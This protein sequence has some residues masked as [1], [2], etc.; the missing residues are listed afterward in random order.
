MIDASIAL[1][2][3]KGVAPLDYVGTIQ[4]AQGIKS[5][6]AAEAATRAGIPGIQAESDIKAQ[7]AAAQK[8]L[9]SNKAKYTR[10]DAKTGQRIVDYRAAGTDLADNGFVTAAQGMLGK[11]AQN[12]TADL[13]ASQNQ[14]KTD[15]DA[16]AHREKL[17][18]FAIARA[19]DAA[20]L[21][22]S[23][24][25]AQ[26]QATLDKW[27]QGTVS[28]VGQEVADMVFGERF[29]VGA[30]ITP[31][32]AGA[33]SQATITPTQQEANRLTEQGQVL[34][35]RQVAVSEEQSRQAGASGGVAATDRDPNS[36][37]SV[38]AR[39]QAIA[40]GADPTVVGRL[41]R[42]EMMATPGVKELIVSQVPSEPA[43]AA[44]ATK[45]KEYSADKG[46]LDQAIPIAQSLVKSYGKPGSIARARW[47]DLIAQ[48]P[49]FAA[50]DAAI[51]AYNKRTGSNLRIEDGFEAIMSKLKVES[52]KL[53]ELT[54]GEKELSQTPSF[55]GAST[56]TA[57]PN[58]VTATEQ[59]A[60]DAEGGFQRIM[61]EFGGDVN[62]AKVELAAIRDGI[63]K[64]P[65]GKDNND[66][67]AM[68]KT[69]ANMLEA[70]IA[71]M[72]GGKSGAVKEVEAKKS[73]GLVTVIRSSD[74]ATSQVSE[75]IAAK[76]IASGRFK[77]GSK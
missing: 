50:V 67:I 48:D 63:K 65:R 22:K 1:N 34:T 3:G 14:I 60:R 46:V 13:V 61:N 8:F 16:L 66:A 32:R 51:T 62:K 6:Q 12:E 5:A 55:R 71:Q 26:K 47:N 38:A 18:K 17:N 23:L 69:Q 29:G 49:K 37:S 40:A 58:K 9:M 10:I 73:G 28:S 44:A 77:R 11:Q 53:G 24:P 45:S 19:D 74:G 25:E 31:S 39:R 56:G 59:G 7:E 27:Y 21:V 70:G 68:L 43:R 36:P 20:N 52:T 2:A 15:A 54:V 4:K 41:S 72:E 33:V 30:T 64:A 35:G 57:N 76:L 75:D 42:A